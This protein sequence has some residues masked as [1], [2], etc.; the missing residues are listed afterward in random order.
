M[1]ETMYEFIRTNNFTR[2]WK[3]LGLTTD[4]LLEL[5]VNLSENP[6]QGD[7]IVGGNGLRKMRI[8]FDNQ[9]K[10]GSARVIYIEF[11]IQGKIY[12]Y[13]VYAKNQQETL[14]QKELNEIAKEIEELKYKFKKGE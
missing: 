14:S 10:S 11:V 3:S 12:L 13:R 9:G 7:I 2:Q 5:E 8:A 4:N 6:T 1:P